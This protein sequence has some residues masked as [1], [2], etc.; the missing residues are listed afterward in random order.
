MDSEILTLRDRLAITSGAAPAALSQRAGSAAGYAQL[1]H[2]IHQGLLD[3][4]DLESL[5]NCRRTG[6]A[7]S[8]DCWSNRCSTRKRCPSTTSS[9]AA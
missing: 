3:R 7:M 5:Q 9:A 4:V 1:K 2:R 8:F 6:S